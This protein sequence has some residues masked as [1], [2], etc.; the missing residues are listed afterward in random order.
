[1]PP[2]I[3]LVNVTTVRWAERH[4]VPSLKDAVLK[5]AIGSQFSRLRLHDEYK[6]V[7]KIGLCFLLYQP[8]VAGRS[9]AYSVD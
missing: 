1:M 3:A 8:I 7:Q 4:K 5:P 9:Y 2:A 6:L